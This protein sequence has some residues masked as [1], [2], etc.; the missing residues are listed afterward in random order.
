M[1]VAKPSDVHV[2]PPKISVVTFCPF[3]YLR[4]K[5]DHQRMRGVHTWR[6]P[7]SSNVLNGFPKFQPFSPAVLVCLFASVTHERDLDVLSLRITQVTTSSMPEGVSINSTLNA[8][9]FLRFS[10]EIAAGI[11]GIFP[12]RPTVINDELIIITL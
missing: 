3:Q 1:G 6:F 2:T 8:E 4:I 9:C 7:L 10:Q 11:F 12:V 5:P